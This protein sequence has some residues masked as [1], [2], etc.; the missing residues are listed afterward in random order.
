MRTYCIAQGSVVI[1]KSDL[2]LWGPG[3][4]WSHL[5]SAGRS[6]SAAAVFSVALQGNETNDI[7]RHS[8]FFFFFKLFNFMFFLFSRC[9]IFNVF[10]LISSNFS[11]IYKFVIL[12]FSVFRYFLLGYTFTQS[13]YS[14]FDSCDTC[15][16]WECKYI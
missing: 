12:L 5:A 4:K 1:I 16:L 9:S 7:N 13:V 2:D 8:F 10:L 14:H 6:D 11:S 3:K 15:K